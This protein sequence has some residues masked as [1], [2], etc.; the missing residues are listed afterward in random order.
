MYPGSLTKVSS[1]NPGV[2]S[3]ISKKVYLIKQTKTIQYPLHPRILPKIWDS[4]LSPNQT[5]CGLK[6]PPQA[7]MPQRG[8]SFFKTGLSNSCCCFIIYGIYTVHILNFTHGTKAL[9]L[10]L[11]SF[12]LGNFVLFGSNKSNL[13]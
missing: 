8:N 9:F 5:T 1:H 2:I 4:K 11:P 3:P 10:N 6:R 7:G 12:F 13:L